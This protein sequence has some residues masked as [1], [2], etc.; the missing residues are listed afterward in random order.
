MKVNTPSGWA[1]A[2]PK[3]INTP[4]GWKDV[5]S[6]KVN[7]DG[8]WKDTSTAPEV[9]PE[10]LTELR[11]R[12]IGPSQIEFTAWG[13]SGTYFYDFDGDE[14]AT[15]SNSYGEKVIVHTYKY[16]GYKYPTCMDMSGNANQ[17]GVKVSADIVVKATWP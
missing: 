3:K 5:A 7:V 8:V 16:T 4:S 6:V 2:T 12:Q 14:G 1:D 15:E 17:Q 10:V 11:W 13:G 9:E